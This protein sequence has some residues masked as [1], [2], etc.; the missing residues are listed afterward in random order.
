MNSDTRRTLEALKSGEITV[1][2]AMLA[3]KKEPFADIGYAKVDLTGLHRGDDAREGHVDDFKLNAEA[4]GD[5][6]SQPHVAA[7]KV[8][9]EILEL[10]GGV[11]GFGA[12]DELALGL[13]LLKQGGGFSGGLLCCR[14]FGCLR[15][16]C[17]CGFTAAASGKDSQQHCGAESQHHYFF[18]YAKIFHFIL[19]LMHLYAWICK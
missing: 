4:V 15:R 2:E 18:E 7:D 11:L 14:S 8:S 5:L 19:P 16:L 10:I 1:D 17:C 13:D 6:L 9:I 12:D 3:L